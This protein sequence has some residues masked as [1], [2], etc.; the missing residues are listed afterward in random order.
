MILRLGGHL[1]FY[2]PQKAPELELEILA[3]TPLVELLQRLNVPTDEVALV[4]I[5]GEQVEL[6]DAYISD[7][8]RVQLFPPIGGGNGSDRISLDG[9]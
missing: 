7:Q 5:N 6:K 8:D 3:R 2:V 4:V 1:S 9:T